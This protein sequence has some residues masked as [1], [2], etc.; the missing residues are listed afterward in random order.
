MIAEL[1]LAFLR[2]MKS[3]YPFFKLPNAINQIPKIRHKYTKQKNM[4][5]ADMLMHI[6]CPRRTAWKST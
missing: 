6:L 2:R 1:F 3:Y 5:V 4:S